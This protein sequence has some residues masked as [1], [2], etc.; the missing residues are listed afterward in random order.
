MLVFVYVD[1][2]TEQKEQKEANCILNT[3]TPFNSFD[4]NYGQ[5]DFYCEVDTKNKPYNLVIISSD[6][7]LGINDDLEEYQKSHS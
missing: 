1:E 2:K 7:V 4:K 5:V 3:Y 6:D